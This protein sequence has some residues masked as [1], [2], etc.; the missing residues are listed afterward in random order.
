MKQYR[1]R[2]LDE[3]LRMNLEAFGAI[4]IE[5]PKWCGKTTT[6][7]Q[8]AKSAIYMQD[9]DNG[10]NYLRLAEDTPSALLRGESPHLI[11]EWQMAPNIWDAVRNEV[12]KRG[13]PGQ[14]ILTG[15]VSVDKSMIKHSGAGRIRTLQ[16]RTMSLWESGDSTGEV[17]L[18]SLFNDYKN[19]EGRS[20]HDIFDI[21]RIVTRGGWPASIGKNEK[22]AHSLIAGYCETIVDTEINSIDG[23]ERD[24]RKMIQILRSLSRNTAM[25]VP[26]TTILKDITPDRTYDELTSDDLGSLK[27]MDIKTV[28]SYLE[29]LNRI[30]VTEDLDAWCPKL[31]SKTTIR[32][33]STRHM[34]DPAI[35]AYFL[36][37]SAED[38]VY[39]METFGLLFESLVIRDLRV[40][41]QSLEGEVFHYRDANGREADAIVHLWNGKWGAVEVKLNPAREDEGAESLLKLVRDIDTDTM[42]PPSFLAVITG[43]GMAHTRKDGVH[44]IPIGCLKN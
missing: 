27:A 2:I 29:A 16:M 12:D 31:R 23:R 19:V 39:D 42:K 32:T 1:P 14:F 4:L 41:A 22:I 25:A 26:D 7:E 21:A 24:K 38:L 13:V 17:S 9:E 35:A 15:S 30:H 11:D 28:R 44:V 3:V 5:G 36:N 34:S 18:E 40:Y 37:A 10:A 33:G 43:R 8:S 20:N 6:A